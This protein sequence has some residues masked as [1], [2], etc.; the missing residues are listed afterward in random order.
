V[1]KD[2][3]RTIGLITDTEKKAGQDTSLI[4]GLNCEEYK[5]YQEEAD[6]RRGE[7]SGEEQVKEILMATAYTKIKERK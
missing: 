7:A 6:E 1:Q 5:L 3:R 2:R 4:G